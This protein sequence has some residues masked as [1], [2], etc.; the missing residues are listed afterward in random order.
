[1]AIHLKL[2]PDL[3]SRLERI[4][5]ATGRSKSFYLREFIEK[6]LEDLEDFYLADATAER[7]RRGVE[8]THSSKRVRRVLGLNS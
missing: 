7:V 4:A 1:M 3:E 5:Q 2:N 6:G 8:A